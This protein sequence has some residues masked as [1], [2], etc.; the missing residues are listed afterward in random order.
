MKRLLSTLYGLILMAV[1][2][3]AL[4]SE[5]GGGYEGIASMY[6]SL[7]AIILIYGVYDTFGK[8]AMYIA[9]PIIVGVAYFLVQGAHP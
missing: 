4:A 8:K 6:Y 2:S 9:T 5:V 1:P 3:L 7:I